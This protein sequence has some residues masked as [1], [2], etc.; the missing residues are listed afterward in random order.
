MRGKPRF[1]IVEDAHAVATTAA[2]L[3][4]DAA[5]Q[6]VAARGVFHWCATGGSTP[7]ALYATLRNESLS[8]QMPWSQTHIWFGDER[9]VSRT[10]PLSNAALVDE[11]LILKGK[12]YM[13]VS[14]SG[15]QVHAWP[16]KLGGP[17]AVASYLMELNTFNVPLDKS[18]FPIFDLL[19]IGVGSDGHC[20]SVFPGS[21]L[22][23]VGA[24][25]AAAVEA[26]THIDPHVPRLTFSL[27]VLSSA[28]SVCVS[29][30]GVSKAKALSSILD[31][32]LSTFNFPAKA[33]LLDT[34]I[35]VVDR[36]ASDGL[37]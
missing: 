32:T 21:E 31:S 3:V 7:A 23:Q 26:P 25:I 19:M 15:A 4:I 30:V 8:K 18:G 14:D 27:G 16:T 22:T 24:P 5:R 11:L 9:H 28:R 35:W 12:G 2:G 17:E 37:R 20:L 6:A 33:A 29:A 13:A 34:A 1:I 10:D 36:A